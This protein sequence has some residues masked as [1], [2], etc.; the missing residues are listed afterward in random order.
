MNWCMR[1]ING[2]VYSI[3]GRLLMGDTNK[4]LTQCSVKGALGFLE[5]IA[6]E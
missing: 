2:L 4:L 1:H 6:G 3:D 5:S